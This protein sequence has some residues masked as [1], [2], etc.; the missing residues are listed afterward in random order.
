MR[1]RASSGPRIDLRPGL[2]AVALVGLPGCATLP[3]AP[4]DVVALAPEVVN[5]AYR[6]PNGT[7]VSITDY[8]TPPRHGEACETTV[9]QRTTMTSEGQILHRSVE[10]RRCGVTESRLVERHSGRGEPDLQSLV[11]DEDH[12]GAF[13]WGWD[14]GPRANP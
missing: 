8:V 13:D 12:D 10:W 1:F 4:P 6:R 3:P 2:L 7:V 5:R 11:V 14:R 9:R